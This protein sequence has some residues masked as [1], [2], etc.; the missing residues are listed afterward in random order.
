M[1]NVTLKQVYEL[2]KKNKGEDRITKSDIKASKKA[3]GYKEPKNYSKINDYD[4]LPEG[5]K[6]DTTTGFGVNIIEEKNMGGEIKVGKGGDYIKDL[7]D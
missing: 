4:E 2:A 5:L 1:G 6:K 7:I 3:L